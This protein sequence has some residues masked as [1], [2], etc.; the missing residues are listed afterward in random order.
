MGFPNCVGVIDGTFLPLSTCP[1]QDD[2]GDLH[3][4]KEHYSFS[5]L[6]IND[7][8]QRILHHVSGLPG[9][10]HDSKIHTLSTMFQH[11]DSF[12]GPNEYLLGDS[13]FMNSP[14]MVVSFG[15]FHLSKSF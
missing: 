10:S 15:S 14:H 6:F 5:S 2:F 7:Y 9:C 12:F 4:P 13:V 11:P 8:N 1:Q 3:G